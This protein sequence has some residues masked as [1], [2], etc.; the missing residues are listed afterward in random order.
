MAARHLWVGGEVDDA[1]SIRAIHCALDAE[2]SFFNT[3]ANYGCGHSERILIL[4][5]CEP[6]TKIK[7]RI[8]IGIGKKVLKWRH[9]L[10]VS[11]LTRPCDKHSTGKP[12]CLNFCLENLHM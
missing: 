6:L 12:R 11:E 5:S 3:A 2:I 8:I 10:L 4:P 7:R 1:E 9:T